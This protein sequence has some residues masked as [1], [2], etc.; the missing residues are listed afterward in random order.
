MPSIVSGFKTLRAVAF[1]TWKEWA[2]Y[3]SHML[4]SLA[5]GPAYFLA[6]VFI[7][8]S[9]FAGKETLGGLTLEGMLLYYG[10]SSVIYYLTMDFADWNLQ[11]L[12]R[13][14]RF[15]TYILRPMSHRFF[16]FS[17]K[18]GHRMLGFVFEF[19]PVWL[20]FFFVFRIPLVP[21]RPFWAALS[22]ALAFVIMFLINYSAGLLAFWLTRT[23]GIRALIRLLRDLLAGVFIPLSFFPEAAQKILF[24]LPFQFTSYVPV[25]VFLG[26][27]DLAGM[28][29]EIHEIVG[30]QAIMALAMFGVTEALWRLGIKRFTGAGA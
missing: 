15:L 14:G 28:R 23:D 27:Y 12:V 6:Q 11:M 4:L 24:F 8:K 18:A 10:A 2:A 20:I 3:R 26:S 9:V 30:L 16:A 25:R 29:L 13:T 22:I 1:V 21:A 7:W 5:I 17:Q 19:I